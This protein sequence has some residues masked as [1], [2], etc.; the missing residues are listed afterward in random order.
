[1][2]TENNVEKKWRSRQEKDALISQWQQSGKSRKAFCV[3]HGLNYNSFVT[4]HKEQKVKLK[5]ESG[6]A[7][8]TV[9]SNERLFAQIHLPGEL[10]IDLFQQLSPE[11]IRSLIK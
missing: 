7:E 2:E 5:A 1:M 8:V 9:Q 3:E 4:W 10:R 6:F 11:F